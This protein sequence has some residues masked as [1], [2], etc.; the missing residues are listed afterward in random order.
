MPPTPG[1]QL[2]RLL[3]CRNLPI[4]Y[5]FIPKCGCTFVKNLL[6]RLDNGKIYPN[7]TRIHDVMDEFAR[8]SQFDLTVEQV[9]A[10]DHCFVVLRNPVDRFLSLYFDKVVGEGYKKFVPLRETLKNYGLNVEARDPADHTRNCMI[11][12]DWIE[13]NLTTNNELPRD[14]HWSHQHWRGDTIKGFN[15]KMITISNLNSRLWLLLSDI[16]PDVE[17]I[18]SQME[19]YATNSKDR[20]ESVLDATVK[21]RINKV[22]RRDREIYEKLRD[23]WRKDNPKSSFEIPR[24]DVIF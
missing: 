10:E 5:L 7:P 11:M 1:P 9:R 17:E 19:R 6:W 20:K 24:A 14:A 2:E 22:Y 23:V 21:N 18:I 15:M 13:T 12:I 16:I 4:R 8:A 3:S